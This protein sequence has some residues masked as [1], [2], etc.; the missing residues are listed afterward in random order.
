MSLRRKIWT[1][2]VK[3][4]RGLSFDSSLFTPRSEP[5][6]LRRVSSG[7]LTSGSDESEG[8][9]SPPLSRRGRR[10]AIYD[11]KVNGFHETKSRIGTYKI[12]RLAFVTVNM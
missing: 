4:K 5:P 11:A 7:S 12:M 6:H 3:L 9:P 8:E 1:R 2:T 10:S